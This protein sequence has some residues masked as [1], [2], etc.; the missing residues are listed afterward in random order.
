MVSFKRELQSLTETA[1]GSIT[2]GDSN[3]HDVRWLRH[4][5]HNRAEGKALKEACDNLGLQQKVKQPTWEDHLLDLALTD[6]PGVVAKTLPALADHKLLVAEVRFRVPEQI[7]V[8]RPVWLHTQAD[9]ERMRQLLEDTDWTPF[10]ASDPDT[11]SQHINDVILDVA[12]LCIPTEELR[13]RKSTHQWLTKEMQHLVRVKQVAEGTPTERLAA[14]ECSKVILEEYQAYVKR[15]V[16]QLRDMRPGNK[17][18]W[19]RAR[20]L[21]EMKS[22]CSNIPAF[23]S[24]DG[25][26]VFDAAGKA[27]VLANT[28]KSKYEWILEEEN[29]YSELKNEDSRQLYQDF[30]QTKR[31]SRY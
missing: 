26:W 24:A 11:L 22:R 29:E 20:H 1:V 21:L 3:V 19:A 31:S 4:S 14:E 27:D 8:S 5:S 9:W 30:P 16:E 6:I 23:K 15:S 25:D 2:V 7:L 17:A 12:T 28:F 18:W 13:Q 10:D